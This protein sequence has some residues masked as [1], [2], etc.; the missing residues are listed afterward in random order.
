MVDT[1]PMHGIEYEIQ[2]PEATE[3]EYDEE[4]QKLLRARTL[5]LGEVG[6]EDERQQQ[7]LQD[8]KDGILFPF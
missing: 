3:V 8:D 7:E 2:E 6:S 1:L 5:C 4:T